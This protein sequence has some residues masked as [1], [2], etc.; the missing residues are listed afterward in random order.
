MIF[1]PRLRR[2]GQTLSGESINHELY[3]EHMT[4]EFT[5]PKGG[6]VRGERRPTAMSMTPDCF[7][8][9]GMVHLAPGGSDHRIGGFGEPY[10]IMMRRLPCPED[11]PDRKVRR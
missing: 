10:C 7:Y 8:L 3:R 11:C 2:N 6:S 1:F 9:S 4:G 5:S